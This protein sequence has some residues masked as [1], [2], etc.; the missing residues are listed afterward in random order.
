MKIGEWVKKRIDCGLD[1]DYQTDK[2]K[3]LWID[4][5]RYN[6]YSS[7]TNCKI[8]VGASGKFWG[9]SDNPRLTNLKKD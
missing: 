8:L 7:S 2:G 4:T 5:E 9:Y 1:P 3:L 6:S